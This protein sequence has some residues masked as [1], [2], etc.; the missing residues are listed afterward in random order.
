META[1]TTHGNRAGKVINHCFDNKGHTYPK[2]PR[3]KSM[4]NILCLIPNDY[5]A[6]HKFKY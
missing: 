3:Q 4:K 5:D 1:S 6:E 2:K